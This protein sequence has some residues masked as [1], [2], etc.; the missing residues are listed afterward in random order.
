MTAKPA[1]TP[2]DSYILTRLLREL[3][4]SEFVLYLALYDLAVGSGLGTVALSLQG[5]SELTGLSK[6]SIQRVVKGLKKRRLISVSL[7]K[8]TSTPEYEVHYPWRKAS[9]T[10]EKYP[11]AAEAKKLTIVK[12]N[13]KDRGRRLPGRET[14]AIQ[15]IS[16]LNIEER[17]IGGPP[18]KQMSLREA[19]AKWGAKNPFYLTFKQFKEKE[20]HF[21]KALSKRE[22]EAW[23]VAQAKRIAPESR[24]ARDLF[25]IEVGYSKALEEWWRIEAPKRGL[26]LKTK[27]PS[28]LGAPK[29]RRA[30][31]RRQ[32][33]AEDIAR[34]LAIFQE[35]EK[36]FKA[37]LAPEEQ[38]HWID[39]H[40]KKL[41]PETAQWGKNALGLDV[42]YQLAVEAW[43]KQSG[44]E[45]S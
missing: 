11:A 33:E 41:G 43:W 28:A 25:G 24:M 12:K 6:S 34:A 45:S 44:N 27:L 40:L 22:Q 17:Q 5:L 9:V 31:A 21:K 29:R 4:P 35:K 19:N 16:K 30:S 13:I 38:K 32:R 36:G 42:S 37:S 18:E 15:S 1:Q 26:T 14:P 23:L 7:L 39:E 3:P 2:V 20:R 10:Q 8:T